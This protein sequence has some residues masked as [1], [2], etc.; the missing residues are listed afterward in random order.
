MTVANFLFLVLLKVKT[1]LCCRWKEWKY[2]Y[3]LG[4]YC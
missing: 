2:T 4:C 1:V 3:F